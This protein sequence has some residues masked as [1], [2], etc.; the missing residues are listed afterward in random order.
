MIAAV[1]LAL[2]VY[3]EVPSDVVRVSAYRWRWGS[4]P[5]SIEISVAKEDR[6]LSIALPESSDAIVT[7]E[8]ADGS[9]LLDGPIAV[10]GRE[11]RRLDGTWR[12]TLI[13]DVAGD[14]RSA[15]PIDWLASSDG[16]R[17]VWPACWWTGSRRWAW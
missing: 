8:R 6:G 13:G 14:P 2:L 5:V 17:T 15:P 4:A 16:S 7:L 3:P 12:R 11:E 10:S 9:Y 1:A